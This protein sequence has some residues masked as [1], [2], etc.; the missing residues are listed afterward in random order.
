M[1]SF[2]LVSNSWFKP[3]WKIK[4]HNTNV[5]SL[6]VKKAVSYNHAEVDYEGKKWKMSYRGWDMSKIFLHDISDREVGRVTTLGIWG[7]KARIELF[8]KVYTLTTANWLWT[9][10]EVTDENNARVLELSLN[11]W[12]ISATI[13]TPH[14]LSEEVLLLA[15]LVF[16]RNKLI[17]M[18]MGSVAVVS[19]G[20][21]AAS[22]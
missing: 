11:W 12:G 17:E 18:Q 4:V 2:A 7:N 20:V 22:S 15:S 16:Y 9:R 3:E 5:G 10:F 13:K 14:P 1:N 6:G 8:G 21:V 19:G